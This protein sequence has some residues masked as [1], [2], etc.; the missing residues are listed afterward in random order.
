[1]RERRGGEEEGPVA[2]KRRVF[3]LPEDI[4]EEEDLAMCRS[5]RKGTCTL[6]KK[7][8]PHKGGAQ[9]CEVKS[10]EEKEEI[11]YMRLSGRSGWRC[12]DSCGMMVSRD[13]GCSHVVC[14]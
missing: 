8:A 3:I 9:A 7:P 14:R 1:M 11:R 10:E 13:V 12:C 4:K 5:C 6:C 2:G